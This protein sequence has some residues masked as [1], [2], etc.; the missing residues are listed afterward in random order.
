M[1]TAIQWVCLVATLFLL[2][3]PVAKAANVITTAGLSTSTMLDIDIISNNVNPTLNVSNDPGWF[4]YGFSFQTIG[5]SFTPTTLTLTFA[6]NNSVIP[7][8]TVGATEYSYP[9][10]N[11][12]GILEYSVFYLTGDFNQGP[13]DLL[14]ASEN[15]NLY[16]TGRD[17]GGFVPG[18]QITV[19]ATLVGTAD[20]VPFTSIA[21][22]NL[23]YVIP[24]PS[25]A[26]L[27]L[28]GL[29]FATRRTRS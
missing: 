12:Y 22:T 5:G 4:Y 20:G 25:A 26:I 3:M 8:L 17:F 11:R 15:T 6:K 14:L 10:P 27:A 7:S 28:L 19:T 13:I 9:I 18:D 16:N 21:K 23:N 2:L 29:L 24:E 1:K